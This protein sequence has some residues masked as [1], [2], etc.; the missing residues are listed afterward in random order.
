MKV[1]GPMARSTAS[2]T[3]AG[4][5]GIAIADGVALY[6][7]GK[8]TRLNSGLLALGTTI[9]NPQE[10]KIKPS[11]GGG[12]AQMG[13]RSYY[14]LWSLERVATALDLKTIGK[15]DWYAWGAEI[16]LANQQADGSWQG[17]YATCGAD[18]CFALLFLKHSNLTPD[19]TAL[20]KGKLK[21]PGQKIV[22]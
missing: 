16:L 12:S 2:M 21:D 20:L 10:G 9:A 1:S 17:N 7:P 8:D 15:R 13:G 4:L 6:D 14:F 5:T 18:T 22:N 3:C 19:L 11:D